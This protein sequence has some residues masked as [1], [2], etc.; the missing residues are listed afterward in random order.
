M[1]LRVQ[2]AMITEVVSIAPNESVYDSAKIMDQR[3]ISSLIVMSNE[4]LHGIIT[5]RDILSRV[6]A[7]GLKP[8]EVNVAD[9]MSPSLITIGPEMTLEDANKIMVEK[10]IKKLPVVE[11]VTRRLLGILSVTDFARLQHRLIEEAKRKML[12]ND[13][14]DLSFVATHMLRSD[15]VGRCVSPE[16]EYSRQYVPCLRLLCIFCGKFSDIN[17]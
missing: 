7:M 13:G 6:V 14:D 16:I 10:G 9:V 15:L 17:Q 1:T 11:P 4:T 5:E 8:S 3:G 2:D 12:G